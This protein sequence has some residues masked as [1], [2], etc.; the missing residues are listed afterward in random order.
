[1]CDIKEKTRGITIPDSKLY[2]KAVS[3]RQYGTG[4]ETDT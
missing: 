1:M 4:T 3:S 2:H